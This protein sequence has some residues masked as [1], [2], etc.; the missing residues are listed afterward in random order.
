MKHLKMFIFIFTAAM[1]AAM[2]MQAAVTNW[3]VLGPAPVNVPGNWS[4]GAV[5]GA[6]DDANVWNNGVA[7]VTPAAGFTGNTVKSLN[8]GNDQAPGASWVG[9]ANAGN[10]SLIQSGNTINTAGGLNIGCT[11]VQS[12]AYG[13]YE[14]KEE[15][16]VNITGGGPFVGG[17]VPLDIGD[18][19]IG[20]FTQNGGVFSVTGYN[21]STYL[22]IGRHGNPETQTSLL[23]VRGGQFLDYAGG[24]TGT[25][26]ILV[27]QNGG[28]GAANA[29]VTIGGTGYV[30]A[31]A[32]GSSLH[33]V[34]LSCDAAP[35]TAILNLGDVKES[36]GGQGGAGGGGGALRAG[37]VVAQGYGLTKTWLNF[38]GGTFEAAIS[39][40]N[41]GWGSGSTLGS[42]PGTW[43][44]IAGGIYVYSEGATINTAGYVVKVNQALL[45]PGGNGLNSPVIPPAAGSSSGYIGEPVVTVVDGGGTGKGATARAMVDLVPGRPTYGQV[46]SVVVTT[47]GTNY[48]GPITFS[49][50]GGGA[51]AIAPVIA[52]IVPTPNASGGLTVDGGGTLLLNAANTYTGDTTVKTGTTLGGTGSIL[53]DIVAEAG[54]TIAPGASIGTLT[55]GGDATLSGSFDVEYDDSNDTIDLLDVSGTLDI[56][57]A[58][59][60]FS[61]FTGGTIDLDQPAYVFAKYGTLGGA[62]QEFAAVVNLPAGYTI[63]YQ[64]GG[65]SIALVIP[66]PSTLLLLAWA[67]LGMA[68]YARRHRK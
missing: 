6:A 53:G 21:G 1:L 55:V 58:T 42:S 44:E 3:K 10:G 47:P 54:S 38:H 26:C 39:T 2:P 32:S 8:V 33:G 45:A 29:I 7:L 28:A 52:P 41:I 14:L 60:N 40:D 35:T 34:L 61:D 59:V 50:S 46:T 57:N 67:L 37:Q 18:N 64:Y 16:I 11:N 13:Y 23:N 56:D 36:L 15:G 62:T 66:E 43:G 17:Y 68:A 30:D 4:T 63:D 19:G 5:P 12:T 31:S 25:G 20:V 9:P 65:D 49:F 22:N 24:N 51:G 27:G 48:A